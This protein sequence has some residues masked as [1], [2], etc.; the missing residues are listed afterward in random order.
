ML[1]E[2]KVQHEVSE[3]SFIYFVRGRKTIS[4]Q[5]INLAHAG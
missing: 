4:D 3:N 2:I 5:G 1:K